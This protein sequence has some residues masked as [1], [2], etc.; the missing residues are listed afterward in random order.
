MPKT[1]RVIFSFDERSLDSLQRI[2]E[3]GRFASMGE[4][5]RESLQISRALQ[6]QA[7]QGFSEIVV[8]NPDTKE[9][10]VIVIPTLHA[11]SSK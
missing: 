5:V 4:A 11:P 2:K 10:R 7:H 6:S 1:Q 3:E 8:R 9:E